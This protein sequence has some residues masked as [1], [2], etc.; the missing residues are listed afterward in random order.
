ML[1]RMLILMM[2]ALSGMM[3]MDSQLGDVRHDD[4]HDDHVD[5]FGVVDDDCGDDD[6]HGHGD[7][8]DDDHDNVDEND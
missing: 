3:L 6:E 5:G 4:D 2:M 7:N 1:S 8:D